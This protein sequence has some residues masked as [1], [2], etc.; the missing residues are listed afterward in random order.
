MWDRDCGTVLVT[1]PN[2]KLV[3]IITDR[4]ICMAGYTQGRAPRDIRVAEAMAK[5]TYSCRETDSV[6]RALQV[7]A[8]HQVRRLPVVSADNR[9]SGVLSL[10]NLVRYCSDCDDDLRRKVMQT[11]ATIS[12]PRWVDASVQGMRNVGQAWTA[13]GIQ[14]FR[15]AITY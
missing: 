9:P 7:M 11:M 8:E 5:E 3:G 6:E 15:S 4:D 13:R 14:G 1:A 2:G 10:N 12:Q